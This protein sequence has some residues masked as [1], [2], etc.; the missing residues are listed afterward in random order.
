[1]RGFVRYVADDLMRIPIGSTMETIILTVQ[2]SWWKNLV[3]LDKTGFVPFDEVCDALAED[4]CHCDLML[5]AEP[6]KLLFFFCIDG[7]VD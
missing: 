3:D 6:V 5:D 1:M 2:I 7:E 4:V